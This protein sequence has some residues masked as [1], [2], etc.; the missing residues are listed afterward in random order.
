MAIIDICRNHLKNI[1]HTTRPNY[2][3]YLNI[4]LLDDI[5]RYFASDPELIN[6]I[7]PK[8]SSFEYAYKISRILL[9]IDTSF[10]TN[11]S[12]DVQE[13]IY[14]AICRHGSKALI[15][16]VIEIIKYS[17]EQ[18]DNIFRPEHLN[19]IFMLITQEDEDI[20]YSIIEFLEE[21]IHKSKELEKYIRGIDLKKVK[22]WQQRIHYLFL[23]YESTIRKIEETNPTLLKEELELWLSSNEKN[24]K[25]L[26][27]NFLSL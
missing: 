8:I 9:H 19:N 24:R 14:S 23:Y 6:E 5:G 16:Q 11:V 12:T 4:N 15:L 13:E 2:F 21:Y 25:K 17:F 27:Y 7:K 10:T 20:V 1:F 26:Y 22:Q 18:N 3:Q